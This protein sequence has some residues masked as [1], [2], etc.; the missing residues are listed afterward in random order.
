LPARRTRASRA[1]HQR[2]RVSAH[3]DTASPPPHHRSS[4]SGDVSEQAL[5]SVVDLMTQRNRKL[6][7]SSFAALMSWTLVTDT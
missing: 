6:H 7:S 4:T 2:V 3:R 1:F 5:G